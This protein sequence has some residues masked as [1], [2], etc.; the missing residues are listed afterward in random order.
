ML[1]SAIFARTEIRLQAVS[2]YCL[3]KKRS[4]IK[5]R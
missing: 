5:S 4:A 2:N 3:P 1:F